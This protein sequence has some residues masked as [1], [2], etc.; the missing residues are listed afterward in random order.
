MVDPANVPDFHDEYRA[1]DVLVRI[2]PIHPD[3]REREADFVRRLSPAA[4]YFRFHSALRELTPQMLERFTQVDYPDNMA[5]VALVDGP[6]GEE[7]VGVARYVREPG[8]GTAEIAIVVADD[9][10][11]RGIA[12][13]LLTDLRDVARRAGI[14]HLVAS[15]LRENG[16]MLELVRRLGFS[17]EP[18]DGEYRTSQLGK[19]LEPPAEEPP[20]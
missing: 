20:E 18:Q 14:T 17:L 7:Q 15:V 8:T 3:D 1:G 4:R 16:R 19:R 2:R 5:L 9:W 6:A 12:T 13:R 10:Q 11:G